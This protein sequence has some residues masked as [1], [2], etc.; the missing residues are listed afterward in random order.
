MITINHEQL[1]KYLIQNN[2]TK[3]KE[4]DNTTSNWSISLQDR[5][6]YILLPLDTDFYDYKYTIK[7]IIYYL[8]TIKECSIEEIVLDI[9]LCFNDSKSDIEI[10][11]TNN[12]YR[13][14][15][16]YILTMECENIRINLNENDLY[17]L[18]KE[19][20]KLYREL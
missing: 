7:G 1:E 3:I 2:W 18:M 20:F 10:Y 17:Q 11:P 14:S 8:S 6:Y 12:P 9:L 4:I 5:T 19:C 16:D 13:L 15:K